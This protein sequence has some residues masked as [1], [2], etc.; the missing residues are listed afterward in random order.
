MGNSSDLKEPCEKCWCKECICGPQRKCTKCDLDRTNNMWVERGNGP[1]DKFA[2][3]ICMLD[4]LQPWQIVYML[5]HTPRA[6]QDLLR[7]TSDGYLRYLA[8]NVGLLSTVEPMDEEQA[9]IYRS[10]TP[11]SIP[12]YAVFAGNPPVAQP[13]R[14]G[15]P[16]DDD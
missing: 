8:Q 13:R 5:E 12:F 2:P 9:R 4:T 10:S 7:I 11:N 16:V 3:G 15:D 14:E 1:L 6:A